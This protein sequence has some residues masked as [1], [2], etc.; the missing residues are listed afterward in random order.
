MIDLFTGKV[1][2]IKCKFC[3]SNLVYIEIRRH[4]GALSGIDEIN[5]CVCRKSYP[6]DDKDDRQKTN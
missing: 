1:N 2:A 6:S 5:C 3:G 4:P